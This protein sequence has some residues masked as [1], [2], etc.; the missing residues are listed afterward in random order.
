VLSL[1][2]ALTEAETASFTEARGRAPQE[3]TE[4][5]TP[6]EMDA[7][8]Q[9]PGARVPLADVMRIIGDQLHKVYEPGLEE[10][11]V[12]KSDR[13]KPDKPLYRLAKTMCAVFGV[14]KVDVYQG[15]RG[16]QIT[17]ENTDPLS[18]VVGP[19]MVRRYQER[20]QRF[21]FAR[22]AYQLRNKM[23]VAYRFDNTRLADLIGNAVRVVMPDFNRL[24]KA[25]PDMTKRLRKAM[26]GKAI[27][28]LECVA[29]ELAGAKTL[30]IGAWLQASTWSADRA[31]LLLS[32]DIASALNVL[33][34]EDPATT[35]IR[36]DS[37]EQIL[38]A[39]RKRRDMYEMF[40]YVTSDDHFKLRT[41]LRLA[42]G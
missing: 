25:D 22:A 17:L 10:L 8:L 39:L 27:K 1:C 7:T 18:M 42:L 2:K 16:A 35:S 11:G 15:K 13:L 20:E 23:A 37:T 28:A 21:L 36:L 32:G 4:V 12:T 34:R 14:E 6:D 19:D 26:S 5:L 9:H 40:S 41:R 33:L 29:Q 3:T 30:D 24:G 38:G 31:G